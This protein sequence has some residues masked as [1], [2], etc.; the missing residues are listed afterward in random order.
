MAHNYA[1]GGTVSIKRD[2]YKFLESLQA[3]LDT[4]LPEREVIRAEVSVRWNK[5]TAE[6]SPQEKL[7]CKENIFLYHF[8]LPEIAAHMISVTGL[9][10]DLANQS[11]RCEYHRK[12][13]QLASANAFRKQGYPFSKKLGMD[14]ATIMQTWKRPTVGLPLNQAYPD[15][16]LS[17]PFPFKIVFDAKFFEEE[18]LASAEKALVE[19]VYEAAHYRGLPPDQTRQGWCYDYGCLLVYD[20]SRGAYLQQAWA[21][22]CSKRLFWDEANVFVMVIRDPASLNATNADQIYSDPPLP[23]LPPKELAMLTKNPPHPGFSIR[24][25]CLD[26]LNMSV[27][28]GAKALGVTRQALNNLVTGKSGISPEMAIR[29]DNAFGGGAEVWLGLQLDYDL[30]QARKNEHALKVQRVPRAVA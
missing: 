2:A 11:V 23:R 27:A 30:A 13:P 12:F 19:G 25:D 21:S 26:P 7:A 20:A 1:P 4:Q 17:N 15:L 29:L 24:H 18:S 5:P 16:C 10:A 6:K 3:R 28:D 8:A 9:D 14:A 22:V